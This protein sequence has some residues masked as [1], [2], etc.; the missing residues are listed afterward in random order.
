MKYYTYVKM[1]TD[2]EYVS[3]QENKIN[4]YVQR[5]N[6]KIIENYF[7]EKLI[8]KNKI[9]NAIDKVIE[10]LTYGTNLIVLDLNILGST[11]YKILTQINKMKTKNITL[12]LVTEGLILYLAN[13]ILFN[14]LD[15]LLTIEYSN[16]SKKIAESKKTRE[17][18]GTKIGRISGKKTSS[19]FDIYKK[20]IMSLFDQG[21]T[22]KRI[23]E[24]IKKDNNN[25][26]KPNFRI[27]D[28]SV[29]ALGNYIKKV[30]G[31]KSKKVKKTSSYIESNPNIQ[32]GFELEGLHNI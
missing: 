26:D 3:N 25:K 27:N 9:E 15:A 7:N 28:S 1:S 17:K 31:E 18:N 30:Q 5:N 16:R 10:N 19:M 29:Q 32:T 6:F 20:K 11:T 21:V 2:K 23:L 12:H 14:V 13:K 22:K 8:T 24:E 4:E